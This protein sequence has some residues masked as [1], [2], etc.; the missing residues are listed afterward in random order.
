[1]EMELTLDYIETEYEQGP[2]CE[3]GTP[4]LISVFITDSNDEKYHLRY[5]FDGDMLIEMK[6]CETRERLRE[7]EYEEG[8]DLLDQIESE[9]LE[10]MCDIM[11]DNHDELMQAWK[12]L[13]GDDFEILE[14][15]DNGFACWRVYPLNNER[16][17]L[18]AGSTY[19]TMASAIKAL[20]DEREL[21]SYEI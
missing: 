19:P 12:T 14:G 18:G 1:M 7:I 20:K 16:M 8:L 15:N 6:T 10:Q 2:D 9:V 21:E 5:Y 3:T 13:A 4:G 11:A 17:R